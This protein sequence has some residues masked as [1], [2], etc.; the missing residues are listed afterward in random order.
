VDDYVAS[1]LLQSNCVV[2][3]TAT[4]G[5]DWALWERHCEKLKVSFGFVNEFATK[6]SQ[7]MEFVSYCKIASLS[8]QWRAKSWELRSRCAIEL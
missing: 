1:T 8:S 5:L 7:F 4:L 6:Q 2:L 3:L